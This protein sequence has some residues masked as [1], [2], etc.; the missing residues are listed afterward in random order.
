MQRERER[1]IYIYR[2]TTT[3]SDRVTPGYRETERQ[4]DRETERHRE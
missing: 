2:E 3:Q 1:D 4:S